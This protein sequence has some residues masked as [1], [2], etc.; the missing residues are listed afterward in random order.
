[1]SRNPYVADGLVAWWDGVWNAGLGVHD[2]AA[3]VWRDL[4]GDRQIVPADGVYFGADC[5]TFPAG[6][7]LPGGTAPDVTSLN[8][9]QVEVVFAVDALNGESA[10]ETLVLTIPDETARYGLAILGR[11]TFSYMTMT[12]GRVYTRYSL[13]G[14]TPA[15][16]SYTR[17]AHSSASGW[18]A[19]RDAAPLTVQREGT[20]IGTVSTLAVAGRS[21]A[22]R[23]IGRI[24]CIRLYNRA[25]TDAEVAANY[26]VDKERFGL[27]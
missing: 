24:H 9:T 2:A 23:L 6:A 4:V 15:S 1:M 25:L 14:T 27:P 17:S 20:T 12:G 5:M 7:G 10:N 21:G 22:K 19:W 18:R 8:A 3:T 13:S 11:G 26:A 16:I